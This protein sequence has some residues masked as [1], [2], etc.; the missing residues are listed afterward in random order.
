MQITKLKLI[1]LLPKKNSK[2]TIKS[3]KFHYEF[4]NI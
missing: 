2:K 4:T 1:K 3:K